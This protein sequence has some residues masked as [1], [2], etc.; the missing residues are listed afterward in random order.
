MF[1]CRCGKK[2]TIKRLIDVI[3]KVCNECK[4]NTNDVNTN[5]TNK[6]INIKVISDH[7]CTFCRLKC[8]SLAGLK[9]Q[10]NT[11]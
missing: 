3:T 10:E 9:R 7:S 1:C 8:K 11:V 4:D 6:K 5:A 2:P